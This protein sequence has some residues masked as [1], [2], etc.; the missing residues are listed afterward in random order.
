MPH[1]EVC[2]SEHPAGA[3]ATGYFVEDGK[4]VTVKGEQAALDHARETGQP[5][6]W[7]KPFADLVVAN[8]GD[9]DLA[10]HDHGQERLGFNDADYHTYVSG[11]LGRMTGAEQARWMKERR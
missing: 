11:G 1:C 4:L 10:L 8:E 7:D 9:L 2:N 3:Y 6:H 5:V